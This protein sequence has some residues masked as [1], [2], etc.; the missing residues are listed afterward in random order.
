MPTAGR[1][2]SVWRDCPSVGAM[3]YDVNTGEDIAHEG[4]PVMTE[5]GAEESKQ[6]RPELI[7]ERITP[8]PG[9]FDAADMGRGLPGVPREF[10]WRGRSFQLDAVLAKWKE[11]GPERGRL[12]GE[13]YLRRHYFHLRTTCGH[14]MVLYCE[15]HVRPG[16][17]AKARWWLYT[18]QRPPGGEET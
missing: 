9:S 8:K 11:S 10:T 15:R 3:R 16:A 2:I 18:V 5:N 1:Q 17:Q 12:G 14:E 7:S 13:R 4:L 6:P